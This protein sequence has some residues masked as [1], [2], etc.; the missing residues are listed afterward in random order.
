MNIEEIIIDKIDDINNEYNIQ[1]ETHKKD[2]NEINILARQRNSM[3]NVLEEVLNEVKRL[4]DYKS[5]WEKL[6]KT[7]IGT[8]HLGKLQTCMQELEQKYNLGGK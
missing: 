5:A 3:V 4:P 6:P 8:T 1:C 7:F 2:L